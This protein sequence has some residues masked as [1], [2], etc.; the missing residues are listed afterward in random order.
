MPGKKTLDYAEKMFEKNKIPDL[1]YLG[2]VEFGHSPA[3]TCLAMYKSSQSIR[4]T[5]FAML[6]PSD[7]ASGP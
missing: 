4:G 2:L 1:T 3:A 5:L 6:Y 7:S